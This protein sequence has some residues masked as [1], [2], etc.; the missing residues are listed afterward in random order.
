MT[1]EA[2]A[3]IGRRRYRQGNIE[4]TITATTGDEDRHHIVVNDGD[5]YYNEDHD[6][7]VYNDDNHVDDLWRGD[8]KTEPAAVAEAAKAAEAAAVAMAR[9]DNNQQRAVKT[10]AAAIKVGKRRQAR[11]RF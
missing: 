2:A 9:A 8:G 10:V 4:T 1:A 11:L 7:D 6:D 5:W 3:V